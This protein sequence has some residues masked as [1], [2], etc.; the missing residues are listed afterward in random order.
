M[1]K[2]N[3]YIGITG[4]STQH[5]VR[6]VGDHINGY[7]IGYVM[8][9]FTSS[10][11]RLLDP[12]SSGKTSPPLTQLRELVDAVPR[13]H[14]PMIHYFTTSPEQVAEEVTALF[15]YCNLNTRSKPCGLQL[16]LLWPDPRQLD[17]MHEY[18][19]RDTIE[20]SN[21][22]ITLQLPK[23]VLKESNEDIVAKLQEY[24]DLIS[25]ALIDPSGGLGIDVDPQ[26]AAKL[27]L[28]MQ[29]KLRTITPGVAGGFS[30]DNVAER[31]CA[32]RL[33]DKCHACNHEK[34]YDYCIDAQGKLRDTTYIKPVYP[35]DATP[36]AV[37][38]LSTDKC[39]QY[40]DNAL[41]AFYE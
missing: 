16:N 36:K 27:M 20:G 25:Y 24:E 14:L 33:V 41:K 34:G 37:S 17:E 3:S 21:L 40:I 31:I 13:H 11:K 22:I 39:I 12:T 8:F 1:P 6:V 10:N 29:K 38:T 2:P 35:L 32:T 19:G 15:E 4:F 5:Q 23:E 26:R 28:L 7:P 9:G 18:F 30:A